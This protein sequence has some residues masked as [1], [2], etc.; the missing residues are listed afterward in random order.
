M[1]LKNKGSLLALG[2]F[3]VPLWLMCVYCVVSLENRDTMNFT[4]SAVEASCRYPP[5]SIHKTFAG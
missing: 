4:R 2:T 1:F 3:I 5:G